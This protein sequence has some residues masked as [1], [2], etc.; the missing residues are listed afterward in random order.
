M[1]ALPPNSRHQRHGNFL[2]RLVIKE[3]ATGASMQ[4]VGNEMLDMNCQ[5]ILHDS[6]AELTILDQGQAFGVCVRPDYFAKTDPCVWVPTKA[7]MP[8]N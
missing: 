4:D 6:S 2:L 3:L 7:I 1:S 5:I 8:K